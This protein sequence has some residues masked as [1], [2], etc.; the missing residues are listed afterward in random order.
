[1]SLASGDSAE[2]PRRGRYLKKKGL[3]PVRSST[4]L[5]LV[6]SSWGN[7]TAVTRAPSRQRT[8]WGTGRTS[9]ICL[10]V[11]QYGFAD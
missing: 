2:S 6:K 1:R 3:D 7:Q 8:W 10:P 4:A 11:V 9:R 5:L